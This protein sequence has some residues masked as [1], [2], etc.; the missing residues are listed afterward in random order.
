M[1]RASPAGQ[2]LNHARIPEVDAASLPFRAPPAWVFIHGLKSPLSSTALRAL[3]RLDGTAA[4]AEHSSTAGKR[5]EAKASRQEKEREKAE[6]AGQTKNE[7]K[8]QAE[9]RQEDRQKPAQ[10]WKEADLVFILSENPGS[11]GAGATNGK[12]QTL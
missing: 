6:T 10:E 3:R 7:H 8:E 5:Q 1:P 2:A 12:D 4:K 9:R 11:T